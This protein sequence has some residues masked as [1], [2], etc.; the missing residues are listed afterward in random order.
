MQSYIKGKWAIQGTSATAILFTIFDA[1]C[2]NSNIVGKMATGEGNCYK[3]A[4][5]F[6]HL[7]DA[8]ISWYFW[9]HG[10]FRL[11][12]HDG[13]KLLQTC[14]HNSSRRQAKYIA[15]YTSYCYSQYHRF[16]NH[17]A[18]VLRL[19][20]CQVC[21]MWF[22]R[23]ALLPDHATRYQSIDHVS[24]LYRPYQT[25]KWTRN[26]TTW[27]DR[28]WTEHN[29]A[30]GR[31]S[32]AVHQLGYH[33]STDLYFS[34]FRRQSSKHHLS[35]PHSGGVCSWYHCLAIHLD[36]SMFYYQKPNVHY[37]KGPYRLISIT[38]FSKL[39]AQYSACFN[40]EADKIKS[41]RS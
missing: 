33:E 9:N 35:R 19:V 34:W 26:H 39:L 6:V 16:A 29:V 2:S 14:V 4:D 23:N 1:D 41:I 24:A 5:I 32:I 36:Y 40:F 30:L 31:E 13:D 15:P 22:C 12:Q 28:N 3:T 27:I 18:R 38:T 25:Q 21:G 7:P 37:L 17:C 20:C 10:A 11:L 8:G